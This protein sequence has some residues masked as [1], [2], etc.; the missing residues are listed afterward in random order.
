MPPTGSLCPVVG[1]HARI[2]RG[3]PNG[4]HRRE[5]DRL[6]GITVTCGSPQTHV[7]FRPAR[8]IRTS[9]IYRPPSWS[10]FPYTNRRVNEASSGENDIGVSVVAFS[11]VHQ[12]VWEQ[13]ENVDGRTDSPCSGVDNGCERMSDGRRRADAGA[14]RTDSRERQSLLRGMR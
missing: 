9:R 12:K 4:R 2:W 7:R 3:Y 11:L 6:A 5:S 10:F 14:R 13:T 1:D 8:W